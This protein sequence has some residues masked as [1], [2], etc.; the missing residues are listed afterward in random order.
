[1]LEKKAYE[2][3][4]ITGCK[5]PIITEYLKE[6]L[7]FVLHLLKKE[8]KQRDE[9]C[10]HDLVDYDIQSLRRKRGTSPAK[11]VGQTSVKSEEQM[12]V[13]LTIKIKESKKSV[14][15]SFTPTWEQKSL[16]M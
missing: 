2:V 7:Q 8:G 16:Q 5:E 9:L 6:D 10:E 4:G 14:E 15:E 13:S 3:I 1:M 11:T 12:S